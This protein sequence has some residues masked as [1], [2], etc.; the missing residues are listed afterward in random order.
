MKEQLIEDYGAAV[1]E[2]A[3]TTAIPPPVREARR[4][5]EN[6]PRKLPPS[7]TRAYRLRKAMAKVEVYRAML[8]TRSMAP[9]RLSHELV[10]VL[11]NRD[12]VGEQHAHRRL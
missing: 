9:L 4:A 6:R 11:R 1:L 5:P 12:C 8:H 10:L 3:V 7:V 2:A